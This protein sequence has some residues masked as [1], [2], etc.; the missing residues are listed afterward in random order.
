MPSVRGL[1]RR[2]RQ[3]SSEEAPD[4][5]TDP[6]LMAR[7]RPETVLVE[8]TYRVRQ[9]VSR[10]PDVT[11]EQGASGVIRVDLPYDGH[12]HVTRTTLADIEQWAARNP[13]PSGEDQV[14]NNVTEG[15]IGHLV[16]SG[17]QD[18]DLADVT[19]CTGRTIAIPVNVPLR[20]PEMRD[21]RALLADR[22]TFRREIGY[23]LAAGRPKVIPVWLHVSVIDPGSITVQEIQPDHAV[24]QSE[25]Y[26]SFRTYLEL[27]IQVQVDMH[28]RK[29]WDP[30]EPVVRRMS[31]SLP[32]DLTLALSAVEVADWR[33]RRSRLVHQNIADGALEWYD[34]PLERVDLPKEDSRTY[35][36][37][38]MIVRINQPGELFR[39]PELVVRADVETDGILLSGADARLFDT[40]GA[41]VRGRHNPLTVRSKVT[42]EATVVLDDA[43]ARRI[44]RPQQKFHF[45][46]V[47]PGHARV[48]DV[49]A[50]LVDLRFEVVKEEGSD[51]KITKLPTYIAAIEAKRGDPDDAMRLYIYVTG[52]R[53]RTERQS[54]HPGGRRYTSKLETGDMTLVVYGAAPRDSRQ[55]IHDVNAL[56]LGLRERFR[57]MR[58]QR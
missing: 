11:L 27:R 25:E 1:F 55:L 20:S 52:R 26:M 18:T 28:N 13:P 10:N 45:D 57:R 49:V 47:I 16:V 36:S 53:H 42:A 22:F 32:S 31:L 12:R 9:E 34:V 24:A 15:R 14:G 8:E 41:R 40:C 46:E 19:E 33:A 51:K 58:A 37:P 48:H 30:P 2:S 54:Q 44:M 35:L 50:A 23:A 21:G 39:E 43:F 4:E 56:Q 6:V 7:A 5:S 3:P 17:H 38:L 29:D